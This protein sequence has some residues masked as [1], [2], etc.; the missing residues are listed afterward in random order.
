MDGYDSDHPRQHSY[1]ISPA[2]SLLQLLTIAMGERRKEQTALERQIE[3]TYRRMDALVY[4]L[5]A[6]KEEKIRIVVGEG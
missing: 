5:Y 4:Q 3:A 2:Q 1:S 6:L